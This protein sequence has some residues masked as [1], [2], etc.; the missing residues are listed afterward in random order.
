[1]TELADFTAALKSHLAPALPQ[2]SPELLTRLAG[3][4]AALRRKNEELNLTG[5]TDPQGMAV[6]HVL[7]S[8]TVSPLLDGAKTLMDLGSG[9]GVPGLPLAIAHPELQVTLVESRERK[10]AA[11]G[12][13]IATL[14]GELGG[15]GRVT[16]VHSRGEEWLVANEVDV[17]VARAVEEPP[18]LLK[19]LRR[20]RGSFRQLILMQG[21]TADEE[22]AGW[23]KRAKPFGFSAPERHDLELPEGAGRRVLL[24]YR[25]LF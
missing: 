7:D 5:I 9:C 3:F 17:V 6:R 21:P 24:V 1:M 2:A 25:G 19:R 13:L 12:Q 8:L 23:V 16:A 14:A 11:L 10:A 20:V 15:A 22:L 4:C 18:G